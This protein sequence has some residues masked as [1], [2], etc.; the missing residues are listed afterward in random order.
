MSDDRSKMGAYSPPPEDYST[1]DAREAENERRGPIL[2]VAAA[3]VL[4]LFGA[5]VWN[6]YH[7]GI[8]DR[9]DPPVVAS[10][11]EYRQSPD[12]PGGYQTPGQDIDVYDLSVGE[13]DT[14]SDIA[15]AETQ[16]EQVVDDPVEEPAPV[17]TA[18]S[19]AVTQ[20]ERVETPDTPAT[21]S[22]DELIESTAQSND[23]AD[24]TSD[25]VVPG[26]ATTPVAEPAQVE[27]E[28]SDPAPVTQPA[29]TTGDFVVQIAAFRSQD[30]AEDGW[31]SFTGRFPELAAGRA[32]DIVRVDLGSR[33]I[34]H[35]L[36][37]AAFPTRD[38]ASDFCSMLS[39]RGQDCL[40]TGR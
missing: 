21:T 37:I 20:Q 10:A 11:G 40:V 14:E 19:D 17:E 34:Y 28:E 35:R 9:N 38:A 27:P 24:D 36:R 31:L 13:S 29:T 6:A 7:L 12:D 1:F 15:E 16:S 5:V 23:E 32:P 26:P 33:G 4:V 18:S 25:L 2:L 3:V 39:D 8:R 30:E 22:L